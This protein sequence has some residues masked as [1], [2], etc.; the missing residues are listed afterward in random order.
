MQ[1]VIAHEFSHILNGD[2]RLNIRM[3]GVLFGIMVLGLI[4]RM[5]LR[6]GYH[7]S[8]VSSRRDRGA[9]VVLI[10]GIG[11]ALLGA[12]GVFFARLIKAA[13]SRQREFLADASAVQFTRQKDGIA[14]ALKKI[15]GYSKSSYIRSADPEEVSHMLF[16]SGARF[17][18]WFAT[19]PPLVERIRALDPGFR[20]S[21]YPDVSLKARTAEPYDVA[22]P[23]AAAVSYPTGARRP[24]AGSLPE[25]VGNPDVEHVAFARRMRRSIPTT[26]YDAAHSVESAYLLTV[27]L[28]LDRSG[29]VVDRQLAIAREQLGGDRAGKV[30]RYYEDIQT[31]GMHYRL[32]LLEI[33]FPALKLR[34]EPQLAFLIQLVSRM[35]DVDGEVDLYEYCFYRILRSVLEQASN[36]AGRQARRRVS[37][38]EL[39]QSAVNL[40]A[41]LADYGHADAVEAEAAFDAG[42]ASFGQW[43]DS[44][45]FDP[46]RGYSIA[47]LDHS[48]DVLESLNS[49]G[50]QALLRAV[51]AVAAHD[52]AVT[53]AEAELIRAVCATL[54]CPLPPLVTEGF[55]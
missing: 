21:D 9:P 38:R 19:H 41:V 36:P 34:P 46:E 16:G 4:G 55:G 2:M 24:L 23:L 43:S 28:V 30:R 26:L 40:L 13:V 51:S 7:G 37:R 31:I 29:A 15:G 47:A 17:F 8:M 49:K 50:R 14:N 1:G 22:A 35:I 39:R 25:A 3:M 44:F 11:L 54:D 5:I 10:V 48:L 52:G 20:E 45:D 27:A 42:R 53:L 6:S 32:P 18:G 12:I 33:A